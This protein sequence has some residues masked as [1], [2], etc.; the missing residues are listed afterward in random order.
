MIP[1]ALQ[2]RYRELRQLRSKADPQL[3]VWLVVNRADGN[4]CALKCLRENT[5]VAAD[6]L[7]HLGSI[8][9]IANRL[10]FPFEQGVSDGIAYELLPFPGDEVLPLSDPVA[11][12][13]WPQLG[14]QIVGVLADALSILHTPRQDKWVLHADIKPSNVFLSR[15]G[16]GAWEIR[17]GDFDA[18]ILAEGDAV[19][20]HLN[21]YTVRS[22]APEVLG[23]ATVSHRADFWSLGM[24]FAEAVM[25]KHPLER[26]S[27]EAQRNLL[28]TDWNPSLNRVDSLEWRA[29]LGGLLQRD[30]QKRWG[31]KEVD[32]WLRNDRA[33]IASGL[34]LVGEPATEVPLWVAGT[35]VYSARA[36][37]QAAL[38]HWEVIQ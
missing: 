33:V 28:V 31:I 21:R 13:L 17:L 38:L 20:A 24:L 8:P 3:G 37:A 22:A 19:R 23:G 1:V 36:L 12:A 11:L 27:A 32:A 2:T 10:L 30:P 14:R 16:T 6:V 25:G 15:Y 26:L 7:L 34:N 35:P 29:L 5:L 4:H 18:A 9:G